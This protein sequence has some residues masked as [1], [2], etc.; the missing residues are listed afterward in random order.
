LEQKPLDDINAEYGKL[1]EDELAN[2][3]IVLGAYRSF[4]GDRRGHIAYVSMP[5]TSGRRLYETLH[6]HGVNS[7]EALTAKEGKDALWRLVIKPNID[8]GVAL[9]DRLGA[10]RKLLFVAPSVFEAK[11][12]R[13]SQEA[14]MSLWYRVIGE[15]AGSHYLMDGWEY[16]TGG[17]KEA[18]FSML[19]RWRMIRRSNVSAAAK[20]FG[21]QNFLPATMPADSADE[22]R[23]LEAMWNIR[24]YDQRGEELHIDDLLEKA[25]HAIDDLRGRGLPY[26]DL[27][28]PAWNI[29][30][31]PLLGAYGGWGREA[32]RD[33]I[34]EPTKRFWDARDR[35]HAIAAEDKHVIST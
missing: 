3:G 12:W 26:Q 6:A 16:S 19:L 10:E 22:I 33:G 14:Y 28:N 30:Q 34:P 17:V 31:T 32:E 21:L 18:M 23:E 8:E 11:R 20:H 27:V 1:S 7:I 25:V 4:R 15:M 24:V 35:L 13:W 29:M 2:L 5:I 9:A